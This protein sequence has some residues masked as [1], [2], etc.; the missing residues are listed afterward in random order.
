MWGGDW[1]ILGVEG[2]GGGCVAGG[3]LKRQKGVIHVLL[4]DCKWYVD[5]GVGI[6]GF[7]GLWEQGRLRIESGEVIHPVGCHGR[8][9][10]SGR[11]GVRSR[12]RRR[13]RRVP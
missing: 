9:R 2:D 4:T 12:I 11:R 3:L 10:N 8:R 13:M 6:W 7:E 1:N 5:S